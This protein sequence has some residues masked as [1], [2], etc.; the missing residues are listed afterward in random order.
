ME[1]RGPSARRQAETP[2][3]PGFW[4]IWLLWLVLL[5]LVRLMLL[6]LVRLIKPLLATSSYSG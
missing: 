3:P 5:K 6:K 1:N 2:A 4:L